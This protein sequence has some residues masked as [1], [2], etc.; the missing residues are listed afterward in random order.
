[1]EKHE[2]LFEKYMEFCERVIGEWQK[3]ALLD[4]EHGQEDEY[5]K[6]QIKAQVGFAMRD[7]FKG[8]YRSIEKKG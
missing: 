4:R 5:I 8:I 3:K 2:I 6:G 1:M 7:A